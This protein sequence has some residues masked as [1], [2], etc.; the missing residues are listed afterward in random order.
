MKKIKSFSNLIKT[1]KKDK[2]I[3]NKQQKKKAQKFSGR[4]GQISNK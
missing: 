2:N 3:R 4:F 1:P